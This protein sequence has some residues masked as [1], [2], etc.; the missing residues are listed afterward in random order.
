[1]SISKTEDTAPHTE[2][3][4]NTEQI[5][6]AQKKFDTELTRAM[7]TL[8]K[9]GATITPEDDDS[10]K[11]PR[12]FDIEID[13][14]TYIAVSAIDSD[15]DPT[16]QIY[17]TTFLNPQGSN[18]SYANYRRMV[19]SAYFKPNNGYKIY[20]KGETSN[21]AG[22]MS[23]IKNKMTG[24]PGSVD[25]TYTSIEEGQ[26]QQKLTETLDLILPSSE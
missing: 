12:K 6:T 9:E 3:P 25:L 10:E 24:S 23:M 4:N 8:K 15:G 21:N 26:L 11:R 13:G 2:I 5:N 16:L 19:L 1:M 18:I 22:Y 17:E 20:T 14:K 7:A